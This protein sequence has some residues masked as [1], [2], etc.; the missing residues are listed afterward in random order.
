MGCLGSTPS[1]PNSFTE[2]EKKNDFDYINK[3]GI[4]ARQSADQQIQL[5]LAAHQARINSNQIKLAVNSKNHTDEN[6]TS[7]DSGTGSAT[8]NNLNFAQANQTQNNN[9]PPKT[10]N[11]YIAIFDY[12]ARTKDD[13]SFKKGDILYVSEVDKLLNG[14]WWARLKST[15]ALAKTEGY[16]PS[17]YVAGIGS[18]ESQ[19]WYF[20]TTKR[21]EAEKLLMLDLN[22]HG[23]FLI[24]ISDGNNHAYSLSVRDHD[25]V[26]HYRIRLSEDGVYFYITKRV[27]FATL[28][29]LV[30]SSCIFLFK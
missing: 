1:K 22:A 16:I 8:S 20:G 17:K 10:N 24:R 28:S 18:L 9:N 6:T 30:S 12:V 19:A 25:S 21:M 4:K 26:K 3:N 13:L 2:L 15:E 23:S 5:Q 29:E 27:P 7:S 11:A 14:W